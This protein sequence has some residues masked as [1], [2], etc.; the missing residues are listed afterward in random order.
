ML[1]FLFWN[2][3]QSRPDLLASLVQRHQVNVVMLAECPT[4]PARVLEALNQSTA[5]FFYVQSECPRIAIYTRFA[6]R[7]LAREKEDHYYTIRRLA[8]PGHDEI[9]VCVVHFPSKLFRSSSDQSYLATE[10]SKILVNTELEIGHSRTL[11][12]GDLNMNPYEDGVVQAGCLHAVMTRGIA[13]RPERVLDGL[14]CKPYFY[15]PMWSHFGER[16][17]G[18]AGTYYYSS[19]KVRADFWNIY[20]QVLLRAQLLPFFHEETLRILHEDDAT[21]VS[22]LTLKGHPDAEKVSD[23][24]PILFSL[25]I[26]PKE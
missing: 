24:L 16:K 10:F 7:Y 3:K 14:V 9:L 18:H 19:P 20:D 25:D 13:R 1:T 17:Q 5:D 22:F 15:N 12:V 2:L 6:E 8:L 21:M 23:H 26:S 4:L 11:L